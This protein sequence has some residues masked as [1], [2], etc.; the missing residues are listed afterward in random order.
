[1]GGEKMWSISKPDSYSFLTRC[2]PFNVS[3]KEFLAREVSVCSSL[4]HLNVSI[5]ETDVFKAVPV[6]LNTNMK[7]V[8]CKAD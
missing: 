8:I 3:R 2:R 1:M 7:L 5:H 6:S 4:Y